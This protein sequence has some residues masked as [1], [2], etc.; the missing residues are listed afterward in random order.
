MKYE[1]KLGDKRDKKVPRLVNTKEPWWCNKWL[2][3]NLI[4]ILKTPDTHQAK[5]FSTRGNMTKLNTF[6]FHKIGYKNILLMNQPRTEM[7]KSHTCRYL[8][9][10]G[11]APLDPFCR[12]RST[13]W[14]WWISSQRRSPAQNNRMAA[15]RVNMQNL[16][17]TYCSS[18][19]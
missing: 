11:H 6:F 13:S 18:Y 10:E 3:S 4:P 15:H 5:R 19:K 9:E 1:K 12:H 2:L 8:M 16:V 17:I 7:G 14:C